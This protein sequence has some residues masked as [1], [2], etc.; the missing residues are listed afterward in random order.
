MDQGWGITAA[1]PQEGDRMDRETSLKLWVVLNRAY[2]AV[3][4]HALADQ[5]RSSLSEGEFAVLEVLYHKGPLLLVEVQRRVLVSSGGIT[6]LVDRLV[7]KALVERRPCST[8]RRAVYAALTPAG[9]KLIG[10]IFPAHADAIAHATSGLT[11]AEQR[12]A[13]RLLKKLGYHAADSA[14]LHAAAD[15]AVEAPEEVGSAG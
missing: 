8:D 2:Q 14:P 5:E 12:Q 6:Y 7:R 1:Y 4:R 15:D 13:I 9:E 11:E 10:D 3:Q